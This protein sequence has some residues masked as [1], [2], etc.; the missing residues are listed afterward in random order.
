MQKEIKHNWFFNQSSEEV[1]DYLTKPELMEQWMV[2]TDFQPVVGFKFH[3]FS[4]SGKIT[5]CEVLE[6]KPFTRLTYSWQYPSAKDN[7]VF[8]S[9]VEWT[10]TQIENGTELLL[11]HHGFSV[12]ADFVAHSNGWTALGKQLIEI[13]NPIKNEANTGRLSGNC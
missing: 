3:F 9:K 8:D 4:K 7:K 12:L 2:K 11:V 6:V 10:L 5:N 1:W 13:L